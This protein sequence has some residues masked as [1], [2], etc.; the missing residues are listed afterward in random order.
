MT[1]AQLFEEK[2]GLIFLA[3]QQKYGSYD[4]ADQIAKKNNMELADL[5][6]IG[7]TILWRLCLNYDP[8][9]EGNFNAYI[10]QSVKWGIV[11]A[12]RRYGLPIYIS[13][14]CPTEK[15][16]QFT[17]HS[18]N[19]H[20][21]GD[22]DANTEFFAV[23]VVDTE[24]EAI[25]R[26]AIQEALNK[27]SDTEKFVLIQRADGYSDKEI[28]EMLGIERRQI[29]RI[30]NRALKKINPDYKPDYSKQVPVGARKGSAAV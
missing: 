3:I 9:H 4:K 5:I 26:V 2:Q 19:A 8:E 28:G 20:K 18:I 14:W 24:Q 13:D 22:E 23:S 25:N 7:R 17:F 12:L 29:T 30:R 1:P 15:R 11:T 16:Q 21:E 6:Q 27:L 10:I